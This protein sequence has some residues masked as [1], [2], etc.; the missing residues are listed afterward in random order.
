[1]I[2]YFLLVS[3]HVLSDGNS[4]SSLNLIRRIILT[5]ISYFSQFWVPKTPKSACP[6][7]QN[8]HIKILHPEFT[9]KLEVIYWKWMWYLDS[10]FVNYP[11][12]DTFLSLLF[13]W[14]ISALYNAMLT[15][16][17]LFKNLL[18]R[19]TSNKSNEIS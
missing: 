18:K 3:R 1:M 13:F 19:E 2:C 6:K 11:G 9:R 17:I 5:R 15:Y 7:C 4:I 14:L 8:M 12:T 16:S 10:A